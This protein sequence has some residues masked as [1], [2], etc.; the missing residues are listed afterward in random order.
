M[1][2][3]VNSGLHKIIKNK[4]GIIVITVIII[5]VITGVNLNAYANDYDVDDSYYDE[6]TEKIFDRAGLL[7]DSQEEELTEKI[8]RYARELKLDIIV[9]TADDSTVSDSKLYA[10]DFFDDNGFGYEY[11]CGSGVLMFVDMYNREVAISTSGLG[12]LYIDEYTEDILD[13]VQ[14]LLSDGEYYEAVDEFIEQVRIKTNYYADD[15]DYDDLY[16]EWY[17]G[18][19]SD[20]DIQ[21][22]FYEKYNLTDSEDTV[23]TCLRNPLISGV[24]AI[25][26]AGI[27]VFIMSLQSKTSVTVSSGTYMSANGLKMNQVQD[28]Y[29]HT[30]THRRK[31]ETDNESHGGG[32]GGHHS[33]HSS[34]G[35]SHGGGS[36]GF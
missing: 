28:I 17:S 14:P 26:V 10:D 34:S 11:E 36:R 9:V 6:S 15:D 16:D 29:T 3:I 32:G 25:I 8:I 18:V 31:I 23:F 1:I 7:S 20:K 19:F 5:S 21:E 27:T 24:I 33:T 13:E 22:E 12:R 4:Y 30:T 2:K 35:H